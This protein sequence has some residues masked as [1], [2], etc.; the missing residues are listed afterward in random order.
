MLSSRNNSMSKAHFMDI[1]LKR[2]FNADLQII[3]QTISEKPKINGSGNPS[4]INQLAKAHAQIDQQLR[5]RQNQQKPFKPEEEI[6]SLTLQNH[7]SQNISPQQLLAIQID[8]HFQKQRKSL[9]NTVKISKFGIQ[10][11]NEQLIYPT[12]IEYAEMKKLYDRQEAEREERIKQRRIE[13]NNKEYRSLFAKLGLNFDEDV[14]DKIKEQIQNDQAAKQI[15]ID[16]GNKFEKARDIATLKA[17]LLKPKTTEPMVVKRP[18]V[19][20]QKRNQSVIN[21]ALKDCNKAETQCLNTDIVQSL[22]PDEP[23]LIKI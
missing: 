7:V 12:R 23:T 14:P 15:L 11:V 20:K 2:T 3:S 6:P 10:K 19:I 22:K 1:G 21:A 13:A 4:R 5:E 18:P 17:Q 8:Q 9:Q 16:L